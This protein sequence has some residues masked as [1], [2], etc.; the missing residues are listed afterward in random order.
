MCLPWCCR[1]ASIDWGAPLR[2]APQTPPTNRF[3][4]WFRLGLLSICLAPSLGAVGVAIP[5][6]SLDGLEP[7]VAAQLDEVGARLRA[8]QRA[9]RADAHAYGEAGQHYH[10]YEL[11]AAAEACY[12]EAER[13][14]PSEFRWPYLLAVLHEQAGRLD[15]AALAFARALRGPDK[16]YPAFIRLANVELARGRLEAAAAALAVAR[17]HSPDDAALLAALGQV[18]LAQQQPEE[19]RRLLTAALERQPKATRLRYPLG[20]AL[21]ALGRRDEARTQLEQ[22]GRIGVQ[23]RDPV[24][25]AMQALR[26]GE[27]AYLMEGHHAYRAGDY[28]AALAAYERAVQAGGAQNTTALVNL[29]AAEQRLGRTEAASGHLE[30]ARAREPDSPVVLYN[31]GVVLRQQ[32]QD[33]RALPHLQRLVALRPQDAEARFELTLALLALGRLE[34]AL[35]AL[36]PVTGSAGVRCASLLAALESAAPPVDEALL[37]RLAA[38]RAR[39]ESSTACAP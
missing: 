9:G 5:F 11:L 34:A 15:E 7:A 38:A 27:G 4:L 18:A 2:S 24:I 31:L 23:P 17:Q 28:G 19:A 3:W 37:A 25:E 35:D 20:L 14:T 36:E 32:G 39:W 29:A 21:R 30:Q 22:A 33:E 1:L 10:A 6:P 26:R 13:Q 16:F 8:A 12:R